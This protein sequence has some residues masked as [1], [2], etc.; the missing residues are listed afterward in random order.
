MMPNLHIQQLQN[1][2][3]CMN[4][5]MHITHITNVFRNDEMKEMNPYNGEQFKFFMDG[6]ASYLYNVVHYA[7]QLEKMPFL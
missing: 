3:E 6:Q 7:A 1:T 5:H 4:T 2:H